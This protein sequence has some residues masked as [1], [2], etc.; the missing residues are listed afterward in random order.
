[1]LR[2]ELK[3]LFFVMLMQYLDFFPLPPP[4]CFINFY[5]VFPPPPIILLWFTNVNQRAQNGL[6]FEL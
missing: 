5:T 4:L 6:R 1:M 2:F 3:H